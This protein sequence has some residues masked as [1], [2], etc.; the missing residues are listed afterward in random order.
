MRLRDYL[1]FIQKKDLLVDIEKPVKKEYEI[2]KYLYKY[3]DKTVFFSNVEHSKY[4]LVGNT[5][6]S[7]RQL[8]LILG[9][10]NIHDGFQKKTQKFYANQKTSINHLS[11]EKMDLSELPIPR[12]FKSDGGFYLTSGIVFAKFPESESTNG[13]IH[14]IMIRS[15]NKGTIRLVPRHLYKIFR[16]NKNKKEDT[17]VAIVVGYHPLIALAC[18]SPLSF[19]KSEI[20]IANSLLDGTLKTMKSPY[21][22]IEIPSSVNFVL[23]GKI[24]A[25]EKEK[26]GPFV[27]ITGTIDEIREQPVLQFERLYVNDSNAVFQ[28]VLPANNEHYI[29]MGFPR[30]VKI[31]EYVSQI[32]PEVHD[33]LLSN[34][35]C[36]WL[37]AIVSI[38]P[39]KIGDAKNVAMAAFAAH[40]SLKWCTV[41]NKDINIHNPEEVEW[42]KI[43]RMGKGDIVVINKVRGSSLD[44]TKNEDGTS[45]K[46]IFDATIKTKNELHKKIA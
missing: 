11:E 38:T 12:F 18:S 30:E 13:S 37:H 3:K 31:Y 21:Y 2:K 25:N 6:C 22:N 39:L 15:N 14:R 44:P 27:D 20:T 17:P 36:G 9:S 45:I 29:L 19:N 35:G 23:E 34:G 24:L 10:N 8:S 40:S 1:N 46:V 4:P 43:T 32:V 5:I 16:E 33:V 28:T 7:R 42:A 26:E 41:V